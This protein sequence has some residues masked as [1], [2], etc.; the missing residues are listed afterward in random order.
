MDNFTIAG[1]ALLLL[2]IGAQVQVGLQVVALMLVQ[3]WKAEQNNLS[4]VTVTVNKKSNWFVVS[5]LATSVLC[6]IVGMF[7]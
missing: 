1:F 4:K 5:V 2:W 3:I 7:V 6:F